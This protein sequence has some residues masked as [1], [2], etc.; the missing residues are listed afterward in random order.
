LLLLKPE[1]GGFWQPVTGGVEKGEELVDAA[2]REASE[3]TSLSFP[4]PPESLDYQFT[5]EARGK[6]FE[7][8]AFSLQ[9]DASGSVRL[10][11]HEHVDF[12]WVAAHEA[13]GELK[14]PSNAE[15]LR[16]LMER[17]GRAK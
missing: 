9:A 12:R 6:T 10:D 7:E 1:R 8:H 5:F 14:H 3:E 4:N 15:G 13:S 2:I 17:Q 16:R 11:P